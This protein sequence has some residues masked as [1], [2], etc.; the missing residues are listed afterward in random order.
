MALPTAY[1]T[2][3]KNLEAIFNAIQSAKA[4]PKFT[5]RFLEDLGFKSAADR[6]VINMLK[7]LGFLSPDGSPT[8]R[9]FEYLDQSRGGWVLAQALEEAY[10]DLYQLNRNAHAL[11]RQ[12]LIG[13][14]KTLTQ[15]Q[16][17]DSV[18]GKMATTFTSLAGLADFDAAR[19]APQDRGPRTETTHEATGGAGRGPTPEDGSGQAVA[20]T[21]GSVKL[22]GLV[23]NIELHLPDSRDPA[24]YEALFRA[25]KTHLLS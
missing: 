13:K 3:T 21:S 18:V 5:Q 24:V 22:G 9:Y 19:A 16:A 6:L 12:D 20:L 25:L 4:P 8:Q 17:S 7:S 23:Y 10:A 11:S 2:S 1:L 15:G 14:I